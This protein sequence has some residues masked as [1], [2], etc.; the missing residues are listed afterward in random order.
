MDIKPVKGPIALSH[1][2]L[3]DYQ[4]CP[5]K[6]YIKYIAK[7]WPKESDSPHLIRGSNVHK[8]LE[9]YIIKK[10]VGAEGLPASSLAEV[11]QTKPFVDKVIDQFT[12]VYP[13]IQ[14]CVDD[15]WNKVE[16]FSKQAYFRAI[17]DML[18]LNPKKAFIGDFKTGKIHEYSGFG[19]QLHLAALMV[20]KA[21]DKLEEVSIAYIYVDHKQTFR[22]DFTRDDLPKLEAHFDEQYQIVN[23]DASFQPK[24]NEFCKWCEA[25]KSQ[26]QYSR[27]L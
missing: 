13:E 20:M 14:L 16:W 1:S 10:T 23:A 25:T 15:K 24:I 2:R 21:F 22:L 18:A 17:I 4:Q 6:F 5:R 27:K 7:E 11:E 9:N 19:G 12:N 3:S 8:A 26:C